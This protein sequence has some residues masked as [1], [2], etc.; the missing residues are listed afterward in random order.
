[1]LRKNIEQSRLN[2]KTTVQFLS[3]LS[4]NINVESV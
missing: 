4:V 3:N 2:A 1:M